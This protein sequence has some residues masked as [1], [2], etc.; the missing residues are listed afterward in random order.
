M[1]DTHNKLPEMILLLKI[2]IRI[3][4]EFLFGLKSYYLYPKTTR[5]HIMMHHMHF[6]AMSILPHEA[7]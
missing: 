2:D 5:K 6:C 3:Q 7:K 4:S 1:S